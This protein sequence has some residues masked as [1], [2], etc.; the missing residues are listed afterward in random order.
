M[1]WGISRLAIWCKSSLSNHGILESILRPNFLMG[2]NTSIDQSLMEFIKLKNEFYFHIQRQKL[3]YKIYLKKNFDK[4]WLNF[5]KI[6]FKNY[7]FLKI[8][9][10]LFSLLNGVNKI[11]C[12]ILE[13][14]LFYC[15]Q[16]N[17]EKTKN[18][19]TKQNKK[20]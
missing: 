2:T 7:R 5:K 11:K 17:T 3:I 19:K 15:N 9:L 6:V 10:Q 8:I 16:K 12:M 18:K 20:K 4:N 14:L 13:V 1:T